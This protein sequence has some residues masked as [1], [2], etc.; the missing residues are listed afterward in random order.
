[1]AETPVEWAKLVGLAREARKRAYSPYSGFSVGCALEDAAG[2]VH[3][4][5]NVENAG[6]SETLCAERTALVKMVSEGN[7]KVVRLAIVTSADQPVFPC[8]SCLQ[9]ISE[10]GVPEVASVNLKGD[11]FEVLPFKTLF[12]RAFTKDRW[13]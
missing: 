12:P 1:M 13:K 7:Q 3:L 9:A 6:F 4:G 8:G 11:H 10:F 2:V 5:C